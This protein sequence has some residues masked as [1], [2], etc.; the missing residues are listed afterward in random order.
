MTKRLS[1]LALAM[2]ALAACRA[3]IPE[4]GGDRPGHA[5]GHAGTMPGTP[6]PPPGYEPLPPRAYA[7]KVKDL[8]TGLP[9]ADNELAA[10]TADPK[11][12]RGLI[13][14][15]MALPSFRDKML[16]FFKKAFQQT[17][18]DPSDLDDMLALNTAQASAV[19]QRKMLRSVEESFARTVLAL[20]DEKAAVH[21]SVTTTRFMLNVPLMVALSYMDAAPQDDVAAPLPAGTGTCRSSAAPRTSS[22]SVPPT[23]DP[24]TGLQIPSRSRSRSIRRHPTSCTG[25]F[26]QPDPRST[27][28]CADPI[29]CTGATP[30]GACSARSSAAAARATARRGALAVHRRRLEHLAHGG[31]PRAQAGE[32]RTTFWELPKLRDPANERSSSPRRAWASSPRSPSSPTGPPTRAT[33]TA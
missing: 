11:A 22:S 24:A 7:A 17:Q 21:E 4:P 26:S 20:I 33:R 14:S 2:S 5:A 30:C 8:L 15:W 23:S 18:L 29:T 32:E 25:T 13:D 9:L 27:M 10:V 3:D 16:D 19:E 1:V 6:T 28:P 12:L 31:D